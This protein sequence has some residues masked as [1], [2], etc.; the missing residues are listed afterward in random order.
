MLVVIGATSGVVINKYL[1]LSSSYP[2]IALA[3]LLI[4]LGLVSLFF[5]YVA[6]F[7]YQNNV[8]IL[9]SEKIVQVTYKNLVDRKV[10]QISLGELEDVS[11][12]QVGLIARSFEFGTLS[13]ETAGEMGTFDFS[14][15]PF[16]HQCAN[17]I[18]KAHEQSIK[19]YG[20]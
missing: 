14:Y 12:S 18:V 6:G 3:T 13:L 19:K 8:I 16:P 17:N 11:V 4:L 7:I 9:T 10:T 5:T 2:G 20:N 15:A 1:H